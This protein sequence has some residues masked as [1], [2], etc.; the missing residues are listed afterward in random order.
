MAG[1]ISSGVPAEGT[2][3]GAAG[4]VPGLR[5]RLITRAIAWMVAI[6]QAMLRL[7]CVS[8]TML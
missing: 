3:A 5:S 6:P 4:V 8:T 2:G 7:S 1:M